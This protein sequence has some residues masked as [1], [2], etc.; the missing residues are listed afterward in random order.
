[1]TE[2]L[3][4]LRPRKGD[5][6]IHDR[7]ARYVY[8]AFIPPAPRPPESRLTPPTTG[9]HAAYDMDGNPASLTEGPWW[10]LEARQ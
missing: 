1:M 5:I 8:N 7:G 6:L 2:T 4:K 3:Y 9:T 10:K